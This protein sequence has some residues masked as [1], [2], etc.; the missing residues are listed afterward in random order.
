MCGNRQELM[1]E[2]VGR[3]RVG[4]MD[5]RPLASSLLRCVVMSRNRDLLIAHWYPVIGLSLPVKGCGLTIC[6]QA[7]VG[8]EGMGHVAPQAF[9]KTSLAS[10]M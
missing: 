4:W 6:L 1:R 10:H 7:Q 8:L 2:W 9:S 3:V 5:L